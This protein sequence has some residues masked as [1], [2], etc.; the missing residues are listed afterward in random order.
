M[1]RSRE[2]GLAGGVV[3]LPG[4]PARRSPDLAQAR[5]PSG[6]R[7]KPSSARRSISLDPID[8]EVLILRHFEELTN[9]EVAEL[10]G[11]QV[12]AASI[13]YVRAVARLRTI[14]MR[15]PGFSD[16]MGLKTEGPSIHEIGSSLGETEKIP[17]A[18]PAAFDDR[19]PVEALADEFIGRRR[20]GETPSLDEYVARCPE[21]GRRDPRAFSRHRRDGAVEAPAQHPSPEAGR[22]PGPRAD[23]RISPDPRDR[24]RW[25]GDRLRGRANLARPSRVAI[26]VLPGSRLG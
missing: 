26:K 24:S 18:D 13:R 7:W 15:F 25:D 17:A 12:K 11:L 10:L 5:R 21:R 2:E 20:K 14:L 23:R 16:D 22:R 8:R 6:P 3:G 9:G 19:D 4:G 1:S